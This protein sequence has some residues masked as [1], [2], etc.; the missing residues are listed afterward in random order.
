MYYLVVLLLIGSYLYIVDKVY[1]KSKIEFLIIYFAPMFIYGMGLALQYEVG[2]D[3]S[4]YVNYYFGDIPMRFYH[5]N[6]FIFYY[7]FKFIQYTNLGSQSIFVIVSIINTSLLF[8]LLNKL[9]GYGFKSWL[10]FVLFF[11][12]STAYHNQMNV[13]RQYLA[14]MVVPLYFMFLYEKKYFKMLITSLIG[15]FSHKIFI[16]ALLFTPVV[17]LFKDKNRKYIFLIFLIA[18]IVYLFLFK[19]GFNQIVELFF[20]SYSFYI[21]SD[22]LPTVNFEIIVTKL[23]YIPLIIYFMVLYLRDDYSK[24]NNIFRYFIFIFTLTYCL[25]LTEFIFYT[26][27][28]IFQ[29]FYIFYIFPLYFIINY[30]WQ[31]KHSYRLI[32]I[33]LYILTPYILKVTILARGEYLYDSILFN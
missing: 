12:V 22:F 18:P 11:S 26:H 23:Y 31:H 29:L 28:R 2:T 24:T 6:E 8:I 19:Y 16:V 27:G 30:S 3:Y 7:L 5:N 4:S 25:Y 9:K 1:I 13:L 21:D 17:V 15:V 33:S 14:V 20:R 10:V 32:I